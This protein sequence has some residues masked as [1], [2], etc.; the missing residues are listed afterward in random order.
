MKIK[1][2]FLQE[3]P[4]P[5]SDDETNRGRWE[6]AY[7]TSKGDSTLVGSLLGNEAP[8]IALSPATRQQIQDVLVVGE[9]LEVSLDE[10]THLWR[11]LQAALRLPA[12]LEET[13]LSMNTPWV[14]AAPSGEDPRPRKATA[15]KRKSET[16]AEE[17][18][19]AP[20]SPAKKAKP[21]QTVPGIKKKPAKMG[22]PRNGPKRKRAAGDPRPK[23]T[24]KK[25]ASAS[26]SGS[27]EDEDEIDEECAAERCSKPFGSNVQWVQCDGCDLWFHYVCV[28]L[29]QKDISEDEDYLCLT[30]RA[31][32]IKVKRSP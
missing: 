30:C 27:D 17:G 12:Q 5:E 7:S 20:R 18:V 32:G 6:H 15:K 23:S 21:G 3:K 4:D 2:K 13:L 11:V 19:A 25:G 10:S 28:G 22:A 26:S 31:A 14:G 24:M 9:L 1:L 8:L 16:A 29:C